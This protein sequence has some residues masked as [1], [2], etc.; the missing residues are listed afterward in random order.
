MS[1]LTEVHRK[2]LRKAKEAASVVLA[3][4]PYVTGGGTCSETGLDPLDRRLDCD[5]VLAAYERQ[6][7][8]RGEHEAGAGGPQ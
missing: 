7:V 8:G 3:K 5:L 4:H 1:T 2:A 6:D